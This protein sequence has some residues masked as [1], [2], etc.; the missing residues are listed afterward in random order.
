MTSVMLITA[1][2]SSHLYHAAQMLRAKMCSL[3]PRTIVALLQQSVN[4]AVMTLALTNVMII[5]SP[6]VISTNTV[7]T[8]VNANHSA[9]IHLDRT[10]SL[11]VKLAEAHLNV[12]ATVPLLVSMMVHVLALHSVTRR[13]IVPETSATTTPIRL[14]ATVLES[15]IAPRKV[16]FARSRTTRAVTAMSTR[17]LSLNSVHLILHIPCLMRCAAVDV[18]A[19]VVVGLSI[20]INVI[21][22]LIQFAQQR[23]ITHVNRQWLAQLLQLW[24]VMWNPV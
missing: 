14:H 4:V 2:T 12:T 19:S 6:L 24:I 9:K 10:T 7:I 16:R 13:V 3:P 1:V 17:V 22:L 20:I 11:S 18:V 21:C 8:H 15:G 23:V 5:V